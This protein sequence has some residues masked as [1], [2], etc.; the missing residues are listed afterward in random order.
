MVLPP[1][2]TLPVISLNGSSSVTVIQNETYSDA[3]A[4][5]TDD[6]DGTVVVTTTGSVKTSTVGTYTIDQCQKGHGAQVVECLKGYFKH[7]PQPE[8]YP[9]E[10]Q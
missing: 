7:F 10:S 2:T 4:T 9:H 6:R 5:A 1:D 3:G 8:G